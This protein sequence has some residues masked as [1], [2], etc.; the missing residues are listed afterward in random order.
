MCFWVRMMM[1]T[2]TGMGV[3]DT[4]I[5]IYDKVTKN[6]D[7]CN[8]NQQNQRQG[9]PEGPMIYVLDR[10]FNCEFNGGVHFMIRLTIYGNF[11]KYACM[12]MFPALFFDSIST[13]M[14]I[15]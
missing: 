4:N 11:S 2:G 14:V 12:Y 7:N 1:G 9:C 3:L 15:M 13:M 8:K 10:F 6:N 5:N